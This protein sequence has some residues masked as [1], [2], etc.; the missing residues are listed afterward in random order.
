M[1]TMEFTSSIIG[2]VIWPITIIAIFILLKDRIGELVPRIEK[3]KISD[4]EI[5]FS[6]AVTAVV[7]EAMEIERQGRELSQSLLLEEEWLV[8][9]IDIAPNS[10][11][12]QSYDLVEKEFLL[13]YDDYLDNSERTPITVGQGEIIRRQIGLPKSMEIKI[14]K[15]K[16]L[17]YTIMD[18]RQHLITHSQAVAYIELCLDIIHNLRVYTANKPIKQ[19]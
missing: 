6:T 9:I 17:R 13:L 18:N 4:A 8:R 19:D 14:G 3:L 16:G 5:E 2:H 1:D 15:I 7:E 10:V 12:H 11:I